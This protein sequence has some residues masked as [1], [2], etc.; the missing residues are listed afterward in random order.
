M[1]IH[2]QVVAGNELVVDQPGG[3][4]ERPLVQVGAVEEVVARGLAAFGRAMIG[5]A[6]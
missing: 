3:V 4:V 2:L 5:G 6:A 1:P